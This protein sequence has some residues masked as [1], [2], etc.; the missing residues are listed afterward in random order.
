MLEGRS[1]A[2][3]R[4]RISA[5]AS[6][7]MKS[8]WLGRTGRYPPP[9]APQT[10]LPQA[11]DGR[12]ALPQEPGTR[13]CR[14]D[15]SWGRVGLFRFHF[16]LQQ[17]F[18]TQFER[19]GTRRAWNERQFDPMPTARPARRCRSRQSASKHLLRHLA[20]FSPLAHGPELHFPNQI[21]GQINRGFHECSFPAFCQ[22]G[23]GS[24]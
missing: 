13:C 5:S 16:K 7:E 24:K 11:N 15:I 19:L 21:L 1:R 10:I 18:T 8:E 12:V 22:S 2:G 17:A 9:K 14:K 4:G 20:E 3:N 6:G 23:S